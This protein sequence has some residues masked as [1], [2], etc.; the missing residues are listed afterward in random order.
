MVTQ[1][2]VDGQGRRDLAE[3]RGSEQMVPDSQDGH[4]REEWRVDRDL[5]QRL[6]QDVGT[7][8]ASDS[9][10]VERSDEIEGVA[11]PHPTDPDSVQR[12]LGGGA[13]IPGAE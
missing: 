13:R 7:P 9:P 8:F 11:P 5:V 6:H 3:D 10:N 12:L 2:D 4:A 1:V